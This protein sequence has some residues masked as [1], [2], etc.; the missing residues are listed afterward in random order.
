[1]KQLKKLALASAIALT[2][3]SSFADELNFDKFNASQS[4]VDLTN[5]GYGGFIW[6]KFGVSDPFGDTGPGFATVGGA[7]NSAFNQSAETATMSRA[8]AFTLDSADFAGV[9]NDNLSLVVTGF[10]F[11]GTQLSQ[12]F[13][14]S[15]QLVTKAVFKDWTNLQSVSFASSGGNPHVIRNDGKGGK[16][17]A[18]DNLKFNSTAPVPE[19]ESYALLLAGMGLVGAA[20][21]RRKAAKA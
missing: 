14:L 4:L 20:V 17:F 21:R 5:S 11:D 1:M 6:N 18:M 15:T 9:W 19:P 2:C 3:V 12:S 7:T 16:Q 10:K 13:E 8:D